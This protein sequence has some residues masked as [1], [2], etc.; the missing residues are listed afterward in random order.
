MTLTSKSTGKAARRISARDFEISSAKAQEFLAATATTGLSS[1]GKECQGNHT[2]AVTYNHRNSYSI[3]LLSCLSH[4]SH[5]QYPGIDCG[6]TRYPGT[7]FPRT[8]PGIGFSRIMSR[9][10][11]GPGHK[12][13]E[14]IRAAVQADFCSG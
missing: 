4:L 1:C 7:G 14:V 13:V 9:S 6:N 12:K 5:C 3:K 2:W 8:Y 11:V 10:R